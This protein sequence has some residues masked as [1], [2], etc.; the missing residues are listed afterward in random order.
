MLNEIFYYVKHFYLDILLGHFVQVSSCHIVTQILYNKPIKF[1]TV[2][3]TTHG[4]R[5]GGIRLSNLE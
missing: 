5:H 4:K 1:T 3:D 2:K